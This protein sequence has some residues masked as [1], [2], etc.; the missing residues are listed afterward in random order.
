LTIY[1]DTYWKAYQKNRDAK[2]NW[3]SRAKKNQI[4]KIDRET[5]EDGNEFG[6]KQEE[7][8]KF[9]QHSDCRLF[10]CVICWL[11]IHPTDDEITTK[12]DGFAHKICV[13]GRKGFPKALTVQQ[14]AEE[15]RTECLYCHHTKRAHVNGQCAGVKTKGTASGNQRQVYWFCKCKEYTKGTRII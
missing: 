1:D 5:I 15:D 2:W 3:F 14:K 9:K 12:G 11:I 4:R 6:I 7:S 10:R 13:D 8:I